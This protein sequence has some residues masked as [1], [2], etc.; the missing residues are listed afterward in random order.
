MRCYFTSIKMATI[1]K[2]K[3]AGVGKHAE[4]LVHGWWEGEWQAIKGNSMEA[5]NK[6]KLELPYCC[7]SDAKSCPNLWEPLDCSIPSFPVLHYLPE[8]AQTHVHWVGDAIQP[9]HALLPT[10]PP[11]LNI[12]QHQGLFKWVN[13]SISRVIIYSL[14]VLLFLF[15]TSL[16][17][18]VQF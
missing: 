10:S 12:S 11:A 14:D 1:K 4:A 6:L 16:L 15:E 9:S 3:I 7:Y 5:L 18:N 2:T 8:F 13:S 17:F